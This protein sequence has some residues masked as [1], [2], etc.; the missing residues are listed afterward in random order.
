VKLTF[1]ALAPLGDD[2]DE[3][4]EELSVSDVTTVLCALTPGKVYLFLFFLKILFLT[5]FPG[6]TCRT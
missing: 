2:D 1:A 6:R 3:D 5:L 4:D